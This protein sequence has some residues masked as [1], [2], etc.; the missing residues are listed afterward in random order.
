MALWATKVHEARILAAFVDEPV[1]VTPVQMDAWAAE[2][3]SWDL[4]DQVCGSLF[5][6]T[7]HVEKKIIEWAADEREFVRRAGFAL[8]AIYAVHAKKVPDETLLP[9]LDLVEHY[10]TDPRNFVK[11]GRQLGAAADRQALDDAAWPGA[12]AGGEAFRLPAQN[13]ALDRQAR[14]T[15]ACRSEAAGTNCAAS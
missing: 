1:K 8:A 3:D 12:C 7:P 5:D 13:R 2:I 14:L 15:R 9:M 4:C 6:R 11:K 10:S